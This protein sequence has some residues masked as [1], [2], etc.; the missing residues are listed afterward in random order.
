MPSP[1]DFQTIDPTAL[2]DVQGGAGGS[3][4]NDQLMQALGSIQDSLSALAS[5]GSSGGGLKMQD[6][7]MFMIALNAGGG[8]RQ[9]QAA[10]APAQPKAWNWENG[11]WTPTY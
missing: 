11:V 4:S 9:Q 7:M 2:S 10:A 6:M 5:S 8:G 3:S 1:T